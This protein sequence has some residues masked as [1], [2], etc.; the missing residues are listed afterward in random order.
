MSPQ[1]A[2]NVALLSIQSSLVRQATSCEAHNLPLPV[3]NANPVADEDP[4]PDQEGINLD[5]LNAEH[6]SFADAVL[7]E[8]DSIYL[9]HACST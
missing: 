9:D 2:K 3:N 4:P 8:Q 1:D 5:D 7:A 6:R